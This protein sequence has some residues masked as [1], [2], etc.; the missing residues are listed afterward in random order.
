MLN[1]ARTV[2]LSVAFVVATAAAPA[3]AADFRGFHHMPPC[4]PKAH[5]VPEIDAGSGLLAAAALI[6]ALSLA[7]ERRRTA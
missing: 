7:W 6:G 4:P 1:S 3:F 2:C 5:G